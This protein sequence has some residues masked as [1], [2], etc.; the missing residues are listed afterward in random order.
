MKRFKF[1]YISADPGAGKTDWAIHQARKWIALGHPVLMVVPTRKLCNEIQDRSNGM[2]RAIHAENKSF[3]TT[4]L[5][6]IEE[7][8][9]ARK[10]GPRGIVI[11]D[12]S[13]LLLDVK[14]GTDNWI[15]I[16]DEPKEPL[17]IEQ[18]NLIDAREFFD[19][20]FL[21]MVPHNKELLHQGLLKDFP[22][23]LTSYDD[24]LFGN[25]LK[26]LQHFLTTPEFEVLFDLN[27]YKS[28]NLLRYSVFTKPDLFDGW[29]EVYF[30]GAYFED[31]FIYHQWQD[32]VE[33]TNKT[34][35]RLQRMPSDRVVISYCF[36]NG[37][38]SNY[39]RERVVGGKTNMA[40]YIE[41]INTQF[42][43]GDYVY[44]ANNKYD[45]LDLSGVRMPAECHGLNSYRH[46]TRVALIGSYLENDVNEPFYHHYG[47]STTDVRGMRNTQYYMQ[48][49]TR[50]AIR[51]YDNQ[52]PIEIC[53]PT[54]K[55]ALDLLTY[56]RKATIVPPKQ[57]RIGQLRK[58]WRP[59]MKQSL[60]IPENGYNTLAYGAQA[61]MNV[62]E[63]VDLTEIEEFK[64]PDEPLS[65]AERQKRH[66][67]RNK[68]VTK[69]VEI[70]GTNNILV[71]RKN[72]VFVT[73]L[74]F[75]AQLANY[76][77][78]VDKTKEEIRDIKVT[79]LPWYSVGIFTGNAL[80]RA[81]C[82][83]SW[84]I[85]FDFDGTALTDAQISKILKRNIYM[86]YT[87]VS[88]DPLD[89]LRRIRI[90]VP[91]NRGVSIE[92]HDR[93]KRYYSARF[94][95]ACPENLNL[96]EAKSDPWSKLFAPH[97]EAV[98]K[99]VYRKNGHK[100]I[101][102]DPETILSRVPRQPVISPPTTDDIVWIWPTGTKPQTD[103]RVKHKLHEIDE[104][105]KTMMPT[106]RSH[107]ATVVGGKLSKLP[108]EYHQRVFDKMLAQGV[109]KTALK[110][111]MNYARKIK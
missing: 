58:D 104:I 72:A 90:V 108:Q 59:D 52:K 87:T 31:T 54:R 51:S 37:A 63:K 29:G 46:Y 109:D 19:D 15:L 8:K 30:M 79:Q 48:Q 57:D 98:V 34:P 111:A 7:F 16:K 86:Q 50:T 40:R 106:D 24:S 26:P 25:S 68:D 73:H 103:D 70:T 11:T 18:L 76:I 64:T 32:E 84:G 5:E 75:I 27:Q 20:Y 33:W 66:R 97:A 44:V 43:A 10:N 35:K 28:N 45:K 102:L 94:K 9:D 83:G 89:P 93:I 80:K 3:D 85:G 6:I 82:A 71:P 36:E 105:I 38:W 47:S 88:Y 21:D 95:T 2:M 53:V 67:L 56:L 42:P 101:L 81:E 78:V 61:R 39:F 49:L 23:K 91:F 92:E 96:D 55:E 65:N 77:S 60:E 14:I 110:S 17:N 22:Y 13:F 12:A 100:N 74:E 1:N 62:I 69:C 41:W 4:K 99:T 107:K